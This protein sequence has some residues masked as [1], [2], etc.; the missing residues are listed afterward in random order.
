MK[1]EVV[2]V[3]YARLDPVTA[4]VGPPG[5]PDSQLGSPNIYGARYSNQRLWPYW[6][7]VERQGLQ[8][9]RH[10]IVLTLFAVKRFERDTGR[11]PKT[12]TELIPKYFTD[13]PKDPCNGQSLG[14]DATRGIIWSVGMDFNDANGHLTNVPLSDGYE[15][16]VSVK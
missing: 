16:T 14:Y 8:S 4:I 3:A 1:N 13:L 7:L 15:P 6:K 11:L 5:V 10:M 9:T 12:L 2:K